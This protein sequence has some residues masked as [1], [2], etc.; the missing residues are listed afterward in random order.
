M[1][2]RKKSIELSEVEAGPSTVH[3]SSPKSPAI[4]LT[5][6]IKKFEQR[7]RKG[8]LS[9]ASGSRAG[10]HRRPRSING[11][12][13]AWTPLDAPDWSQ[14]PTR[15]VLPPPL[16]EKS[17]LFQ[18]KKIWRKNYTLSLGRIIQVS[19]KLYKLTYSQMVEVCAAIHN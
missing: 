10:D 3:L 14:S 8:D 19:T 4:D 18:Y 16:P 5:S 9:P 17:K 1:A 6:N 11:H 7:K 13:L 15:G 2:N 12:P